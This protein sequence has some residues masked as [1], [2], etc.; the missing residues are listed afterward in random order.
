MDVSVKDMKGNVFPHRVE[1][2]T[3]VEQLVDKIAASNQNVKKEEIV[4]IYSGKDLSSSPKSTMED[5][6]VNEGSTFFIV[7]R[8]RG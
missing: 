1:C 4:L 5:L 8:L 7:L 2:N 6:G 3:T